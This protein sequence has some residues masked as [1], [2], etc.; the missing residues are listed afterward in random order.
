MQEVSSSL[1]TEP[2]QLYLSNPALPATSVYIYL[3]LTSVLWAWVFS[4]SDCFLQ[5]LAPSRRLS[6]LC[7]VQ[8]V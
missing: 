6:R 4:P 5:N 2:A 8:I 1:P 3:L 7:L